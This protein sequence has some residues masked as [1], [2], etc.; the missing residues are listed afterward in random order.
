MTEK[1]SYSAASTVVEASQ[2]DNTPQFIDLT[3][4]QDSLPPETPIMYRHTTAQGGVSGGKQATTS[5]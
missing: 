3:S 5:S 2:M 4:L 1:S